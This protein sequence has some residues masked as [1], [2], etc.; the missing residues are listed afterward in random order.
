MKTEKIKT[1]YQMEQEYI[2]HILN[3]F[4]GLRG[5]TAKALDIHKNTLRNRLLEYKQKKIKVPRSPGVT[6]GQS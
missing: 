5:K 2:L 3:H 4:N 1:L 6:N